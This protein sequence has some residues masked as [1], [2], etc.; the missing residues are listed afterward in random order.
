MKG[1]TVI[2]FKCRNKYSVIKIQDLTRTPATTPET[3]RQS[4]TLF[5]QLPG[6]TNPTTSRTRESTLKYG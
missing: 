5:D 2:S 1:S 4:S 3:P 6:H